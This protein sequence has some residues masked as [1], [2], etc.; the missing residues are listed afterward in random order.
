MMV[1]GHRPPPAALDE[2]GLK[3]ALSALTARARRHGLE[4]EET[5]ELAYEEGREATRH[6]AEV[7]T[8]IYRITQEGLTNA[9]KHG[10]AKRAVIE[11]HERGTTVELTIADDGEGFDPAKSTSGFGLLG[12][13]ERA[14][15]LHGTVQITSSPG[16][17]TIVTA[18]IPVERRPAAAATATPHV[19]RRTAT[20]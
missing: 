4:V 12:M 18:S 15:L 2:L 16:D 8:T 14:Q 5:V 7:E 19:I 17:G 20:S 11:I 9:T 13:R 1:G 10:H 3:A 6:T